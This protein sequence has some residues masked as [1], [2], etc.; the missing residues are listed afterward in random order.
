RVIF[1]LDVKKDVPYQL[2][3]EI[4]HKTGAEAYS[5]VITYNVNQAV[6][7]HKVAPDLM[8]SVSVKSARE[9]TQLVS[10]NI[11]DNRFVAFVGLSQPDSIL[12]TSSD[13]HGI[14]IIP[15]S[16]GNLDKPAAARGY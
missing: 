16:I 2:L 12:V 9:L 15:G 5:V 3:S 8:I 11:P 14:K 7:L 4:I 1:T 10:S 6:A 13:D